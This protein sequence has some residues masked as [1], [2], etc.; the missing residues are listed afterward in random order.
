MKRESQNV[1]ADRERSWRLSS[2]LNVIFMKLKIKQ[3]L[4]NTHVHTRAVKDQVER[5]FG[6]WTETEGRIGARKWGG[7]DAKVCARRHR[8]KVWKKTI[9]DTSCAIFYPQKRRK[10]LACFPQEVAPMPGKDPKA[11]PNE[12]SV[13][14]IQRSTNV[15]YIWLNNCNIIFGNMGEKSFS[16]Y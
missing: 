13:L 11:V 8:L 12:S 10:A 5:G 1:N 7:E 3:L 16:S 14:I 4:Q 6:I 15:P 9:D 2:L